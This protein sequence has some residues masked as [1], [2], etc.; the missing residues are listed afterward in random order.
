MPLINCKLELKLKWTKYC[1]LFV[2]GNEIQSYNDNN[3]NA[4]KII[5]TIK[6]TKLYVLIVTLSA[7]DN[8]KLS[9]RSAYWNEY[10]TKSENKNTK[11]E[12]R[13]FLKSNFVRVNRLFLLT[14]LNRNNDVKRFNARKYY[15]PKGII[16]N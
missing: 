8:E 14:Y 16:T 9:K 6:D 13:Y 3:D 5:F 10:K 4:N 12:F 15:L 7:K 11:N 1:V 2:A